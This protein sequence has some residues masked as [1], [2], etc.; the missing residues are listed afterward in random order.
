[1]VSAR[2]QLTNREDPAV[3]AG[4]ATHL[5]FEVHN[6]NCACWARTTFY[7]PP[8]VK[9]PEQ[10]SLHKN[11]KRDL[12]KLRTTLVKRKSNVLLTLW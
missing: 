12:P 8:W 7:V 6:S 9:S 5:H 10:E 1:M 11:Q 3:I 2:A 4:Q